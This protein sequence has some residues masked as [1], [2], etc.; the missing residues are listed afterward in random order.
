[1]LRRLATLSAVFIAP[2][3][4]GQTDEIRH[5]EEKIR[6]VL[7][8][9]CQI[10]H[11]EQVQTSGLSLTSREALLKGGTRGPAIVPGSPDES[12]LLAALEQSGPLQMPP[13][14]PLDTEEIEAFRT[15]VRAGA[16]WGKAAGAPAEAATLWSFKPVRRPDPPEVR[17]SDWVRNPIDNFVL[18][19][20]EDA[21]LDPS[22]AADRRTLIRRA[23]LDLTGLLP[24]PSDVRAFLDDDQPGAYGRLVE[25][26][27]ESPHYGERWGRH[28]LDIARYAD[29]N[30]YSIDGP[31]SI[32]R[33]RDWVINA[34]NENMPFD[35]FVIEQVAGDLLP[36]ATDSQRIATGLHRNTMINQEG[37]IDFEQYRVEAVV[38]RVSTTGVAFL[39]LTLG[40]ARCHDHKFDP[41]S[42]KE[43]YQ[44]FAF[45]N[46]V[47]ELG[48]NLE[49]SVGRSRMMEPILEFGE[50]DVL[51]KRDS[52]RAKIDQLESEVDALQAT[53]EANWNDRFPPGDDEGIERARHIISIPPDQRSSIQNQVLRRVLV[54]H[55]E[56]FKQKSSDIGSIQ[57]SIPRI[58]W[59]HGDARLERATR[60]IRPC[61]GGLHSPRRGCGT[62]HARSAPA[63]SRHRAE[64]PARLGALARLRLAAADSA[65]HHEPYLAALL[66]LGDRRDRERFRVPRHS[67]QP[68]GNAGLAGFG[69]RA[70]RLE[71]Q[72]H[73]P[74]DPQLSHLPPGIALPC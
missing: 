9:K 60:L 70:A 39:G 52:L 17:G 18:A 14:G 2:G 49:E 33:Y 21:G 1:M 41:I 15:W 65:G 29:T 50:P 66:R 54:K 7:A 48:G 19:R 57:R 45:F 34:L 59:T 16:A 42:Q 74:P 68:S 13:T 30:G 25:R 6:P 20:L 3:L 27:L 5:F 67:S 58:E 32:W 31:R 51:A 69:D 28:W 64:E 10:C 35:R 11:G 53:L 62:G 44:V 36:N 8:T 40:C 73:A 55:V 43:F 23:S 72:G 12:L 47:D 37:G 26:L 61:P 63:V 24:D 71:P 56:E 4:W 22:P 46:N 38:D